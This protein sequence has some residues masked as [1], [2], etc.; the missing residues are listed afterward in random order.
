M[1]YFSFLFPQKNKIYIFHMDFTTITLHFH[2][3]FYD[4]TTNNKQQ[5]FLC[6]GFVVINKKEEHNMLLGME[7]YWWI[8]ILAVAGIMIAFK[9]KFMR[10]WVKRQQKKEVDKCGKWGDEE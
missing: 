9:V 5:S 3:G 7:W 10:W 1:L 2:S 6:K 8:I 4:I